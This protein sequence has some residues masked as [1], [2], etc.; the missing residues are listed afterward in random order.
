MQP[1]FVVHQADFTICVTHP[2]CLASTAHPLFIYCCCA[3]SHVVNEETSA[4]MPSVTTLL[5]DAQFD[6][7]RTSLSRCLAIQKLEIRRFDTTLC[8]LWLLE[9]FEAERD[10]DRR[11]GNLNLGEDVD[12]GL[13]CGFGPSLTRGGWLYVH[14]GALSFVMNHGVVRCSESEVVNLCLGRSLIKLKLFC[15]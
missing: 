11:F 14:I 5:T 13:R 3:T 6:R 15:T 8:H 10:R 7:C 9:D 2:H 12:G 4:M 1:R